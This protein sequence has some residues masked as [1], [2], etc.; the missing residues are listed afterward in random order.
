MVALVQIGTGKNPFWSALLTKLNDRNTQALV[1]FP[2]RELC[3][4]ISKD[5]INYSKFL[6][7]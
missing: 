7:S 1:C 4:Q 2:T 5:L 3:V 6:S